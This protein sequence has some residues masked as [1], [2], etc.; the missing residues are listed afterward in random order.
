MTMK[1]QKQSM[2]PVKALISALLT[3]LVLVLLPKFGTAVQAVSE[4]TSGS[5]RWAGEM[6]LESG[7]VRIENLV[8]L[9]SD[10]TLKVSTG[11]SLT[12]MG[13]YTGLGV[14]TGENEYT[15]TIEGEGEVYVYGQPDSF[16]SFRQSDAIIGN[17]IV[18][19]GT[20]TFI[21]DNST[22]FLGSRAGDGM[23]GNMVVNGGTVTVMGGESTSFAKGGCGIFGNVVVNGG[24]VTVTGGDAS[25][26][27][28]G[29]GVEGDVTVNGGTITVTG[30]NNRGDYRAGGGIAGT[31]IVNGGFITVSG[32]NGNCNNVGNGIMD[33]SSGGQ[34]SN[35]N[36]RLNGGLMIAKGGDRRDETS[37][38]GGNAIVIPVILNGGKLKAIP[39]TGIEN[40]EGFTNALSIDSNLHYSIDSQGDYTDSDVDDVKRLALGKLLVPIYS[41][42]ITAGTGMTKTNNSGEASQNR[43]I[44]PMTDVVYTVNDGYYFPTG[45]SVTPVKGVS[46]TRN[47]F[48]QIT[49]SGTPTAN[50]ALV[51]PAATV[52]DKQNTP[53]AVFTA[54]G[55]DTGTLSGLTNG[56]NY[57]LGGV[58]SSTFT[59]SGTSRELSGIS[60]GTISLIM[61]GN[62]ED[63]ADSVAQN[64]IVE[65]ASTPDSVTATACS[66][67]TNDNGIL[68]GI[69][70]AMEYRK[71]D[72]AVWMAG[73]GNDIPGLTNGTYYV[74]IKAV[75][76]TL[77]SDNQTVIVEAYVAPVDPDSSSGNTE[78]ASVSTYEPVNEE[79]KEEVKEEPKPAV[80]TRKNKDG[81]TTTITIIRNA[82]GT[83]TTATENKYPD[84]ITETKSETRDAKGNGTLSKIKKDA[85][86]NVLS[87]TEGTI[88]VNKKGTETLKSVTENSDGST[89]EKTQKTYKRDAEN[90]KKVTADTK[91]TDAAGN[92]EETK[93]TALV[94]GLGGA[95]ITESSTF[96]FAEADGITD[97]S[98]EGKDSDSASSTAKDSD[99]KSGKIVKEERQYSLSVNGRLKLFSLTSDGEK[100]KIPESIELDGMVRV[101][102]SIGKNAL[103]GNKTVREVVIEKDV[104]TICT[105]AFKNCSNLELIELTGSVKKVYKNAFKGIAKNA[106]FVI[107]A[108]EEDFARIV[109]LL[110]A[111]GVSDTVTFERK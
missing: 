28:A 43:V 55:S 48:S 69:T 103:K 2:K 52:Q 90:I 12:V 33:Y 25:L 81:S 22:G 37:A 36:V 62:G 93:M 77:A 13:I 83:V 4:I 102:K 26:L 9:T 15:L 95:T 92:T 89:E 46:V 49:V 44:G 20:V 101:V 82:D 61:K 24:T 73:T 45:Y 106:R 84:G 91:K 57:V 60:A 42:S 59:A 23:H 38:N 31:V 47:S 64:I 29:I 6:I 94:D 74:R 3:V 86:G 39:G 98:K 51:L 108:S 76:A 5:T 67:T 21:G 34:S 56:A 14:Y 16:G 105:G 72:S 54:T 18:D 99:S 96:K 88:K 10:V 111:S 70:T 66:A 80:F 17:V 109:E 41:T 85:D 78:P 11:S 8:T 104:T 97:D 58:I 79:V 40:G 35:A 107:E 7:D 19:G 75:G 110:K 53:Q 100:V 65:K 27:D 68:S 30:G 50:T 87:K 32:G 63:K 1:E 71:S